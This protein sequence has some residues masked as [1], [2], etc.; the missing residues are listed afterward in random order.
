M[1]FQ[2]SF[3][4]NVTRLLAYQPQWQPVSLSNH[5]MLSRP[6]DDSWLNQLA[7][8]SLSI[9]KRRNYLENFI[10]SQGDWTMSRNNA[11]RSLDLAISDNQF[12]LQ[13]IREL[14]RHLRLRQKRCRPFSSLPD[15]GQCQPCADSVSFQ[16]RTDSIQLTRNNDGLNLLHF[17]KVP[18][19]QIAL[20]ILVGQ[21]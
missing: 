21:Q 18:A 9:G 5:H 15:V 13:P 20:S 14:T 16:F 6:G 3:L 4:L 10:N 11:R 1:L 19:K 2:K 12:H 8:Y 7:I 17:I